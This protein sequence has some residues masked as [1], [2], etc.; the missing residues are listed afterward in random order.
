M[1]I[2]LVL[3]G[4]LIAAPPA[5][6]EVWPPCDGC[7]LALPADTAEPIPLLVVLHGDRGKATTWASRWREAALERG[8]GVLALQCPEELGCKDAIWYMW[9]GDAK[10][11]IEQIDKLGHEVK[12]DRS[13]VYLAGFSGG[14]SFIGQRI[15]TWAGFAGLVF[16]AGAMGP[17]DGRCL[18]P[19]PP[20]Y[21]LVG[22][23]NQY[24]STQKLVRNF[25]EGC[26]AKVRWDLLKK[27]DHD[28][29]ER[30]LTPKKAGQIL[31]WLA[32]QQR[33]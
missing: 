3:I 27:G 17:S 30:A 32:K 12:L 5:R 7:T 23:L 1:R 8:M 10:W 22:E 15:R 20:T 19:T 21:F 4:L 26:R 13:K 28:D 31:D 11:V 9:E 24:H 25:L 18:K 14:A 6:A 16:H 33:L 29:E 2:W